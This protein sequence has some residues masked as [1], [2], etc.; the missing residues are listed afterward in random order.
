M[1]LRL[2]ERLTNDW[3]NLKTHPMGESQLLALLKIFSYAC[4]QEP[5]ITVFMLGSFMRGF[6][7][8]VVETDAETNS[9]TIYGALEEE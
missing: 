4:R 6:I 5:S 3:P 8:R 2:R 7:H 1:E 9:Q